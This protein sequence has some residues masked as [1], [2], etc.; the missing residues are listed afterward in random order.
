MSRDARGLL[1]ACLVASPVL[2]G[3]AYAAMGVSGAELGIL[4]ER[5]VW[6]GVLWSTWVAGASTALALTAAVLLAVVFRSDDRSSRWARVA[7]AVPLPVPHVVAAAGAVLILGQSGLL[8]RMGYALG[9][10][11]APPEMPALIYDRWGIGIIAALAWK[12]LGFLALVAFSVL[13]IRAAPLEETARTLGAGPAATF[14]RITLPILLRGMLPAVTA[15]FT[16][17]LGS[18]ETAALLAPSR[19]LALPLL[20]LER[21]ASASGARRAESF[22]LVLLALALSTLAVAIH[23]WAHRRTRSLE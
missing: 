12:E 10:L 19:P 18:Y 14:R 20:T 16:F 17:A 22:A 8:A 5:A 7:L 3:V 6:E 21:Y 11:G 2:V 9:L 15:V 4:R 13:A 23:E 1:A